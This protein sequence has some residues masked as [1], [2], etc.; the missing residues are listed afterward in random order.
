MKWTDEYVGSRNDLIQYLKSLVAQIQNNTLSVQAE[1]VTV[2]TDTELS[3]KV[4]YD[5]DEEEGQL[6]VKVT[7][8]KVADE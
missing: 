7:W 5:E 8:A 3:Y 4:K 2:P 6:S 1:S